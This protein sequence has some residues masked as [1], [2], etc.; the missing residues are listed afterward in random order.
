ME[1]MGG[2]GH[3]PERWLQARERYLSTDRPLA[4]CDTEVIPVEV[5]T[6]CYTYLTPRLFELA[7]ADLGNPDPALFPKA[8][9]F[10]G[11]L[12]EERLRKACFGGFGKEFVPLAG[13]RDI[14]AVDSLSPKQY[15]LAA[16]WC[17]LAPAE[18]GGRACL[19]EALASVFW[20][21]ENDPEAGFR[22]CSAVSGAGTEACYKGL[23]ENIRKYLPERRELCAQVPVP[24]RSPCEAPVP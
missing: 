4:P 13:A 7:G 15:A 2:A 5:K 20:G 19:V 14:R 12:T 24:S 21:G 6:F 22:F 16:S 3:D 1:L 17:E 23:A 9:S 11:A 8:F 18:D 10:C